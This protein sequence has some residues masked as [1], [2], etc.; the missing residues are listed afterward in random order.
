MESEQ[1]DIQLIKRNCKTKKYHV[2]QLTKFGRKKDGHMIMFEAIAFEDSD[3]HYLT[4]DVDICLK[5]REGKLFTDL[6]SLF[7]IKKT[8]SNKTGAL[9]GNFWLDAVF[10]RVQNSV[11]NLNP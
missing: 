5:T 1:K 2:Q 8:V 11:Q 10:R 9:T 3:D 6:G 4:C 7:L